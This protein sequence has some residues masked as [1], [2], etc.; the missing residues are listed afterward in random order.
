[1]STDV[2][3]G[4]ACPMCGQRACSDLR[5]FSL[6]PG[7]PVQC[8]ECGARISVSWATGGVVF[9]LLNATASLGGFLVLGAYTKFVG[10]VSFLGALALVVFGAIILVVP[11]AWVYMRHIPLS[12][13]DA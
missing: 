9:V 3:P 5:K 2:V 8:R 4:V 10:A 6:G 7:K 13:R 11:L 12:V 1:M